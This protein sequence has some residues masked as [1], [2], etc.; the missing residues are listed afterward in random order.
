MFLEESKAVLR[1]AQKEDSDVQLSH[2]DEIVAAF[3]VFWASRPPEGEFGDLMSGIVLFPQI[4]WA[5]AQL[6]AGLE[7][8]TPT[9]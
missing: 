3:R 1:Q 6:P 8:V 9:E 5:I 7:N 2:K 4:L